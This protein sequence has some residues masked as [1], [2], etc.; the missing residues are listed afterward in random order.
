MIGFGPEDMHDTAVANETALA[1]IPKNEL[2]V[3]AKQAGD[4]VEKIHKA[5]IGCLIGGVSGG[6]I[7]LCAVAA[8]PA[9]PVVAP[10]VALAGLFSLAV[11]A[12][13]NIVL[14]CKSDDART[15]Q[16][17][18]IAERTDRLKETARTA[19]A[20][21]VRLD[22]IRIGLDLSIAPQDETPKKVRVDNLSATIN[23]ISQKRLDIFAR[24]LEGDGTRIDWL[25]P[26]TSKISFTLSV[27]AFPKAIRESIRNETALAHAESIRE[28]QP[29]A[30]REPEK[31]LPRITPG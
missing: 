23:Q 12:V 19:L 30:V 26:S 13:T 4:R 25:I 21:A 20:E 18:A 27:A 22:R 3:V 24:I 2:A 28:P 11:A 6:L 14:D 16:N 8:I 29:P 10:V 1:L 5:T 17:K 7:G 15:R 9:A 31:I